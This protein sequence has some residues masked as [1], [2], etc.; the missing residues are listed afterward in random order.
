VHYMQEMQRGSAN[1]SLLLTATQVRSRLGVDRSTVYRM[2][3][4]GRLSA[5]KVGRQWRFPAVSIDGLLSAIQAQQ[6]VDRTPEAT[7]SFTVPPS[8]ATTL[9]TVIAELLGVMMLVTDMD[10]HPLTEVANPCPWF[11]ERA[12]DPSTLNVC[13]A[14]WQTLAD[15]VHLSPQFRI[16][17]LGFECARSYVRSGHT[18]V[19]M[20]LAGGVSPVSN[21]TD[22]FYSLDAEQRV[23]VLE[24]LPRIAAV[25]S[26]AIIRPQLGIEVVR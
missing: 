4:D 14:E 20:V 9:I 21:P 25:L 16:G 5:V 15:D 8:T 13:I 19:G 12:D 6:R 23:R 26:R 2:A 22:G 1:G 18:L 7:A 24:T 17:P 10:G 11:I 3:L